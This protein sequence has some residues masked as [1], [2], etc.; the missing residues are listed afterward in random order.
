MVLAEMNRDSDQIVNT[1]VVRLRSRK[2][3]INEIA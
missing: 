3:V 2:R 1:R